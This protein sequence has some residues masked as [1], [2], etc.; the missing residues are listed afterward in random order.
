MKTT[1]AT[2]E[3]IKRVYFTYMKEAGV[4]QDAREVKT[5]FRKPFATYFFPVGDDIRQ[6]VTD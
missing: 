3:R 1:N 6:I 2:N 4:E 5:K